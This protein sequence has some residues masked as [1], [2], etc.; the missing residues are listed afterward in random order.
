MTDIPGASANIYG[1]IVAY[2]NSVKEALLQ[3]P[4]ELLQE[5]GPVSAECAK[6]MAENVR[7]CLGTDWGIGATGYAGR[8]S[9]QEQA[10]EDGVFYIYVAGRECCRGSKFHTKGL[11]RQANVR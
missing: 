8:N 5:K 10:E 2:S 11:N 9:V 3:I 4:S 1:G 7:Q 6:L